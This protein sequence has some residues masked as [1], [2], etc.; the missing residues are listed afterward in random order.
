MSD[1]DLEASARDDEME[2]AERLSSAPVEADVPTGIGLLGWARWTW[3]Q[4]TSMRI[5]L[6]LLFLLSLAAIPGSLIPQTGEN[7]FKVQTW[8]AAHKGIAP[9]Y[10][11]LQ[12]FDVYSSV[13]FS[14]IY[15]LLFVSLAGCIIPRTWQFVG[16]IR[17]Q[18]RPR[19]AT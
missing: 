16:V 1:T 19:R 8:K 2:S 15:I 18:P 6:M 11:K 4:L 14:A 3:R 7:A 9:L 5:A 12:L 17:A 13:W 10:E